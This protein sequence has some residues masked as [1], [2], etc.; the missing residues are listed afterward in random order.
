MNQDPAICRAALFDAPNLRLKN[1]SRG[2][3]VNL[4]YNAARVDRHP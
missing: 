1:D 2:Q 4:N 3:E